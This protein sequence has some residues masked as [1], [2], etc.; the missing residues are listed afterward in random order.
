MKR[1]KQK[2]TTMSPRLK[3]ELKH[4]FLPIIRHRG[5]KYAKSGRVQINEFKSDVIRSTVR[6]T[7]NYSVSV[8]FDRDDSGRVRIGCT[9]P[10]FRQGIPC[11][12]IWATICIADQLMKKLP[13]KGKEPKDSFR[14]IDLIFNE[15][16]WETGSQTLPWKPVQDFVI[17]YRLAVDGQSMSISIFEQYVKKDGKPG[18][19][20]RISSK[21]LEHPHLPR[22][23]K[24]LL[25]YFT[26]LAEKSAFYSGFGLYGNHMD[27]DTIP[28]NPSQAGVVLPLLAETG[29]CLVFFE[30]GEELIDPLQM[31]TTPKAKLE[32]NA[33]SDGGSKVI[34][35]PQVILTYR[36]KLERVD[37]GQMHF[38]NADPV[39]LIYNG[40]LYEL[41]GPN[42]SWIRQVRA[43]GLPQIEKK[44]LPRL[45]KK[46]S[47][48]SKP[49]VLKLHE[50]LAP[51]RITGIDPVLHLTLDIG[52]ENIMAKV[53]VEYRPH[54]IDPR[55][56]EPF[57]FDYQEWKTIE[58]DK[59]KEERLLN[60]LEQ[61][62]FRYDER[63]DLY[64]IHMDKASEALVSLEKKGA[65]LKALD[66]KRVRAGTIRTV[67]ITSG[68][69]WFDMDAEISFGEESVPLP[70]V[71]QAYLRGEK[72]ITLSSGEQGILPA[73][74]LERH[75]HALEFAHVRAGK[76]KKKRLRFSLSH[77]LLLDQML[78]DAPEVKIDQKFAQ[79]REK[80]RSFSG[81]EA[82]QP[83]KGFRGRLRSYQRE[84]LGWFQFLE[85]LGL[86]GILADDMGLG[87]T[88]QVLAWLLEKSQQE[89]GIPNLVVAPT[90]LVFN[91]LAEA[92]KFTPQLEISPYVGPKRHEALKEC[93]KANIVLT[94]Y[95]ILRRDIDKLIKIKFNYAVLD[96]SQCIKNPGSV[97]AKAVRLID[98]KNRLCLTGTPL[99]NHIGELW[100]QMEFLNPGMLGSR[101]R[102]M[103][104][105]AKPLADGDQE[106]ATTL[107][108]LVRPFILR[109]TKEEV[110]KE[111]PEKQESIIRCTMTE[112]QREL[113]LQLRDHYR[114]T[115][116]KSVA[117]KGIKR[118]KMKV[119]EGLLRLRQAASH[120][121]LIGAENVDSGKFLQL[122]NLL[123]EVIESGH[124]VL[125]FSQFTKM[126]GIIKQ[127]LSQKGISFEYLDGRTPQ[128][129]R[130]RKVVNFQEN[131]HIRL[132]LI[133]LRAGGI[134]LNLTAADYVFI[135][136]PWW[137]P[138]V[139]L[140]AIDRTHRIGQTRKVVTYRLI[141][142]DTVEE[143]V[144]R[145][146]KKKQEIVGSILSGSKNMLSNLTA[147]DLEILFS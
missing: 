124:K 79:K 61:E 83:P 40:L 43:Y 133:S 82:R 122:M 15:D 3:E 72:T 71:V 56:K 102:F 90:S 53:H 80:I 146:Q 128:T 95:G 108:Q 140:Q 23:D 129:R 12:H 21:I 33:S 58:R 8:I 131:D 101:E 39:F 137:N 26:D 11:K 77:A 92:E 103:K 76:D 89:G 144:L 36:K 91:W 134:G 86:G 64:E 37:L 143:K 136:D 32:I 19:T 88:V 47:S 65:V 18:R 51:E 135:V 2:D 74:W 100:S 94:T 44:A 25:P 7:I 54:I 117:D 78:Q 75:G 121:A 97:I 67:S 68:I 119:L 20:R 69:D 42:Y 125:V 87:K 16:L 1:T 45:V 4:L 24:L 107:R 130:E 115:I 105:F 29:R 112:K 96:E 127:A 52:I 22:Q 113:Y 49:Q 132:F 60:L 14:D 10:F 28:I 35:R 9:C 138:A 120:P 84:A 142:R 59:E 50:E 114:A 116:L 48:I 34:L 17:R 81:I 110:A 5:N 111:L 55:S 57:I 30:H 63:L 109:R 126:L 27:F 139:E 118:S 31:A 85:E 62:G 123:E 104:R 147:E 99:E 93:L 38:L 145:L 46:A 6:G 66:K 70:K 13:E 73:K 106:V 41:D 98:A 141:S